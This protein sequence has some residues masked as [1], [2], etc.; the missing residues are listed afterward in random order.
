MESPPHRRIRLTVQYDGS[1]FFGWQLQPR[2][3]TVQG[4]LERVLTRLFARPARVLGSGRTDRGVHAVGQ[5]ASVDAPAGWEPD[6]LRRSMN[7]LLSHDVWIQEAS[8]AARRFHPRYDAVS[9]SYFYR[10][11]LSEQASSPFH[12]RWCWNYDRDRPLDTEAMNRAARAIPGDHSFLAFAKAGQEH[13]GDRCIV[14]EAYWTE[15]P[16]LGLEF[17]ISA[18]RFLHHMVRYLVGTMVEIGAGR[19]PV[20]DIERMLRGEGGPETSPPAP[21]QGLFLEA[22]DYPAAGQDPGSENAARG[23][24]AGSIPSTT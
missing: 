17:N 6:A 21:P 13:R 5:V 24:E 22:V 23:A 3:R 12:A 4:E 8:L 7:A 10:V 19:R 1:E 18:N 20:E 11:G 14:S 9:R 16:E 2:K 15:W